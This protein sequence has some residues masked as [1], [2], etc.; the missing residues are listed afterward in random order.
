MNLVFTIWAVSTCG[1]QNGL[2]TLHEGDCKR[3]ATLTFWAHL[4]INILSTLLLGASNY[5][6]QCLSSPTRSEIDKAHSQGMCLDVGVPSIK[7]LRRLSTSRVLLWWLLAISSVPLHLLYNSAVF[8]SLC[9]RM[10]T[11]SLV[12]KDFLGGAPFDMENVANGYSGD[13]TFTPTMERFDEARFGTW[14][15]EWEIRIFG[16]LAGT[17]EE[18]Q[19]NHSS[20]MTLDN[21]RCVEVYSAP[22]VS[23][24]SDL[25]LVS[26]YSNFHNSL[27]FI[28]PLMDVTRSPQNGSFITIETTEIPGKT[29]Y[30]QHCLS[31]PEKEHCE[32]QFSL[33]IMIVVL[34][35]NLIKTV[36]MGTMAWKQNAEPLVTLGDA[37]ASFL[38]RPDTTTRGNCIIGKTQ[39]KDNKFWD[40]SPC[41]WNPTNLR[42]FRAASSRRW[43][44]CIV[45]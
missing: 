33:T 27:L 32:L 39:F 36:C 2:G 45:L 23:T 1:V 24:N 7:N 38:D 29:I 9:D 14:D 4:A 8:S 42:W 19:K 44:V 3:T 30:V 15:S 17:L 40:W 21:E 5:S 37:I 16:S 10:Y 26:N 18:Y 13:V 35:C 31:Q 41:K 11:V 6:M 12:S 28:N 20:L 22:I 34:I 43:V 25:L